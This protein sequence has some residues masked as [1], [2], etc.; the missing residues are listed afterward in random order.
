MFVG[1]TGVVSR[2]RNAQELDI[3]IV[4]EPKVDARVH[5]EPLGRNRYAWIARAE[6]ELARSVLT[7][8]DLCQFHLIV[9]APTAQLHTTVNP[10]EMRTHRVSI[11]HEISEFGPGLKLLVDLTKEL[12][13]QHK[14][15]V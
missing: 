10:P 2:K 14:V 1:D 3:A 7:S 6:L 12:V 4:S 11:C 15:L 9:N 8:A 13:A 5:T